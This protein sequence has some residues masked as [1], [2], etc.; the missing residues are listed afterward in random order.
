MLDFNRNYFELFNLP[1]AFA[2]DIDSLDAAYRQMQTEIHP[3]R[4]AHAGEADQRL[5]VQWATRANEA[6]KTLKSPFGR[7]NYLLELQGIHAMDAN[8]TSMPMDFLVQQMEWREM[9]AEAVAGK[10]GEAL[11]QLLADTRVLGKRLI[12]E[13]GDLIDQRK[14]YVAAADAVRKFRFIEKFQADIHDAYE[15]IE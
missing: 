3:D 12:A 2:M 14:D 5:A 15:T 4:F 13:I 8:N 6:Y 9:L 10:N 7:A 1:P 11:D